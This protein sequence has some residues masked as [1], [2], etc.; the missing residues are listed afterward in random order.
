MSDARSSSRPIAERIAKRVGFLAGRLADLVSSALGD[1]TSLAGSH[2]F[3]TSMAASAQ[4]S[5]EDVDTADDLKTAGPLAAPHPLDVLASALHLSAVETDLLLLAGMPEEHEGYGSVLRALHPRHEPRPTA[6]LAAQLCCRTASERRLLREIL[7]LGPAVRSGALSLTGEAPFFER[8]LMSAE[9]LWPVLNGLDTWP[10]GIEPLRTTVQDVGLDRWMDHPEVQRARAALRSQQ[11]WLL[12]L[13]A[14]NATAAQHRA[15]A[16]VARAGFHPVCFAWPPAQPAEAERLL[17]LHAVCR[18]I[19][20]ILRLSTA[21]GASAPDMPVLRWLPGPF[22]ICLSSGLT[23]ATVER[24]VLTLTVESLSPTERRHVWSEALPQLAREAPVLASRYALEPHSVMEVANDAGGMA[25][26]QDDPIRLDDIAASV[27]TRS[28]LD[29]SASGVKLMRPSVCWTDLVLPPDHLAQLQEAVARLPLQPRVLDDWGFLRGR[30]GARGVRMLFAGAP[31]TGKTLAAQVMAHELGVDLLVVDLARVVS[32]WI[33]ETEKNLAQVFDSAERA[34]VVLLFDEADALFGR[35]TEVSD[36]HDRY[37]NLETAY[38]LSRLERFEGLAILSTNLR[39]NI[40]PAFVRRLEFVVDFHDPSRHEREQLWQCHLPAP[41]LDED[42][43]VAHLAA[44]Y[45]M[46][47]GLIR[48]AAVAAGFLAAAE[49][50]LVANHHLV[51]AIQREY[52]KAGRAFPGMPGVN[53][54]LTSKENRNGRS[55]SAA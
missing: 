1:E 33:G 29:L 14:D 30:P 16:L 9:G 27:R 8:T 12:L 21:D 10:T 17:A 26:L 50:A 43:D 54:R 24:P 37:A 13:T 52:A 39:Q 38:L 2:A 53:T 55:D 25:L 15:A 11:P 5:S 19:I 41:A 36:A 18:G 31:G 20:P 51:R 46:V 7:E 44:L 40:D 6:G 22:V 23:V 48:N 49:G 45:P 35:R 42:V 28:N 47:G 34:Q 32:K 3:L 4:D